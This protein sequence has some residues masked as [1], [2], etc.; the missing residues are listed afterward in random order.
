[1]AKW[2]PRIQALALNDEELRLTRRT[3]QNQPIAPHNRWL[4][5]RKSYVACQT[6]C[7]SSEAKVPISEEEAEVGADVVSVN[8]ADW[9]ESCGPSKVVTMG[10]P[11]DVTDVLISFPGLFPPSSGCPVMLV[12]IL[13]PLS[14]PS[15]ACSIISQAT[16]ETRLDVKPLYLAGALS[17]GGDEDINTGRAAATEDIRLSSPP[18]TIAITYVH[19]RQA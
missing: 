2:K 14:G 9:G 1:M 5:R 4:M 6:R 3:L 19:L 12:E 11:N 18:T 13:E 10:C 15:T 7:P 17:F 8:A 16:N